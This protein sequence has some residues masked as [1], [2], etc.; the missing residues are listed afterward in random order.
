MQGC[1]SYGGGSWAGFVLLLFLFRFLLVMGRG[2]YLFFFFLG[3]GEAL[4]FEV[5]F[6]R[7][8]LGKTKCKTGD[9]V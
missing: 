3:G 7:T 5:G 6:T 9:Q 8:F 1:V 2:G 4:S